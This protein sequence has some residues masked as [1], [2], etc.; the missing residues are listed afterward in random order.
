M[1]T[2]LSVFSLV[3]GVTLA[4]SASVS[5]TLADLGSGGIPNNISNAAGTPTNGMQW[6]IVVETVGSTFTGGGTSYNAYTAGPTTAGFLSVNGAVTHDY[7]IPGTTTQNGSVW[8]TGNGSI[9]D[10]INNIP[11]TNGLAAGDKFALIW[12]SSNPGASTSG[13]GDTYGFFTDAS[14]VLPTDGNSGDYGPAFVSNPSLV[15]NNPFL[16]PI[17]EPSRMLLL[18][19]GAVAGLMVRRRPVLV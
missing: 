16:A 17:P 14:F 18:G 1:K 13:T 5:I 7:Y 11:L 8:G 15:G 3:F 2:T 19:F 12:F 9:L 4:A 10:D 6:G